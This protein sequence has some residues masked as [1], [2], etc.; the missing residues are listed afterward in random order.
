MAAGLGAGRVS[1]E[2]VIAIVAVVALIAFIGAR[3]GP[4]VTQ[5]TRTREKDAD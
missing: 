2:I 1:T 3:A 5:I 4:R